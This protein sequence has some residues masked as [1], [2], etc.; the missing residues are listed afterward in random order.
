[1]IAVSMAKKVGFLAREMKSMKSDLCFMQERCIILEEENQRLRDGFIKGVPPE[2]DV[3]SITAPLEASSL[4]Q[5]SGVVPSNYVKKLA[6]FFLASAITRAALSSTPLQPRGIFL[7]PAASLLPLPE[8]PPA[9]AAWNAYI[10]SGRAYQLLLE[11]KP[12][13]QLVPFAFVHSSIIILSM[14][15][16]V[17]KKQKG[18]ILKL[19][20]R[21]LKNTIFC[22]YTPYP[23][24]KIRR[25][26]AS[27]AQ[28]TR[29]DQFPIW[30]ALIVTGLWCMTRSSTKEQL[31]PLENPERVLRS[32]RKLFDNPSL[33][34]SNPQEDDQLSEIEEHIEEEEVIL[35]YNGLDVPTRQIL[36]SKAQLNNLGREIKKVNE[37][38]YAAQ[39]GCELCKGPHYT[40]DC[41][42]KKEGKTLE[43]AY[44]TQF[45]APY[46]PGGQYRAPGPG[47]YQRNNGNSSYPAQRETIEESLAKFMAESAK[48]HEENSNIIK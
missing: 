29:N 18:A 43:E 3:G 36:D 31:S 21:H 44:Y 10:K 22:T 4:V 38:V 5:F 20:Q 25:I 35:F 15:S 41:P 34:E 46:Q 42:Q 8:A 32:R 24:M 27:S 16:L 13:L 39:V 14:E 9:E 45:G 11:Q 1:M 2:E 26:S 23:A 30:H 12:H 48:R 47:F 17:K 33:V 7:L 37:K 19:K 28:E 40:K 6:A